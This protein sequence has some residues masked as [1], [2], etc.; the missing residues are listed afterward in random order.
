VLERSAQVVPGPHPRLL[1]PG[2]AP[3]HCLPRYHDTRH[4][5]ASSRFLYVSVGVGSDEDDP[6]HSIYPTTN[7]LAFVFVPHAAVEVKLHGSVLGALDAMYSSN[8][9]GAV[10]IDVVHSSL[11][12]YVDRDIGFVEFSSLVLWALEVT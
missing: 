5:V 8:A 2:R 6:F 1:R 11:G 4:R 10:I 3:T 9:A 7:H 12:K